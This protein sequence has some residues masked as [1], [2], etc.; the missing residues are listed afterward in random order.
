LRKKQKKIEKPAM[1]MAEA[2]EIVEALRDQRV[3]AIVSGENI[4]LLQLH[5]AEVQLKKEHDQLKQAV[6][7]R[8]KLVED[9][10]IHQ[11]ELQAQSEELRRTRQ[12]AQESRDKYLDLYDYA[13]VA[14]FTLDEHNRIVEANLTGCHLLR[15]ERNNVMD[16]SF[17]KYID[18]EETERFYLLRKKFLDCGTQQ[19][20]ELQMRTEEGTPFSAQIESLKVGT[21]RLRF[22]IIDIT[23][24]RKVE[25]TLAQQKIDL[26]AINKELEAF[27]YSVSHD[28]RAPL[29]SIDGFSRALLEDYADKLD[30]QGKDYLRRTQKSVEKMGELIEGM[31]S[32]SQIVRQEVML[33]TVNLSK[34]VKEITATLKETQPERKAKFIVAPGIKAHGDPRLIHIVLENLLNNAWKFTGKTK[35]AQIEFGVVQRDGKLTYFVC[36]NGAGFDMKYVARLFQPFQRLHSVK[37]YPGT[38]IGLATIRRIIHRHGGHIWAEGEAGKGAT[39]Y[40]TLD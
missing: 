18:P 14:Y 2:K 4:F 13:P 35:K 9:L 11:V 1:K 22:A 40:F 23:E 39:F 26:E 36:D 31:L 38:G 20:N 32:L 7:E 37:E 3:D 5:D 29:R 12:E 28:L 21:E 19:T 25:E 6:R 8:D 33:Q 17:T 34:M 10:K 24:R 30:A 15:T 16:K 27:S